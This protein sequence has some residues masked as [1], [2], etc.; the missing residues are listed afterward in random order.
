MDNSEAHQRLV[1]D[2]LLAVGSQ[3]YCRVWRNATGVAR[4]L[5]SNRVVSFGLK[6]SPDIIGILDSGQWL[7]IEVKTGKAVQSTNQKDFQK[8]VVKYKGLYILARCVDDA[9]LGIK[10]ARANKIS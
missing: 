4:P 3:P 1:D 6:G 2:I 5:G 7:G 9:V 8:M 10:S